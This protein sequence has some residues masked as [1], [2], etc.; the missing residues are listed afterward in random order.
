MGH[1]SA[2]RDRCVWPAACARQRLRS[3]RRPVLLHLRGLHLLLRSDHGCAAL[4]GRRPPPEDLGP[5]AHL[6]LHPQHPARG[7]LD[8]HSADHRDGDVRVGL[9][10]CARHD[11]GPASGQ[12]EHLQ[13]LCEAVGMD[14]HLPGRHPE[15]QRGVVRDRQAG[16]GRHG[17]ARR[18][19][20]LLP[21]VDAG[22]ARR[23]PRPLSVGVV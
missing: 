7:D 3:R 17:V 16:S 19:A 2:A 8:D 23:R 15:L 21:A 9:Q 14:V 20:R 18:P 1:L 12:A 4:L 5:K 13:G 22:E 6:E 10:G 11:H